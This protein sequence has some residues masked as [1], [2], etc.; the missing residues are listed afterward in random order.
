MIFNS[1]AETYGLVSGRWLSVMSRVIVAD[2]HLTDKPQTATLRSRRVRAVEA[3]RF[4]PLLDLLRAF[5]SFFLLIHYTQL[6]VLIRVAF[7]TFE[8]VASK[9]PSI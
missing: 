3:A 6:L 5:C 1:I 8:D 4:T 9:T 2:Y 7:C